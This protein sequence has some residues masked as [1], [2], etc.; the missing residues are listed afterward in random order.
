MDVTSIG[1]SD[2]GCVRRSNEDSIGLFDD[3]DLYI[4]ADGMGGHAAGEIASKMAVDQ[5][6]NYYTNGTVDGINDTSDRSSE[7][8]L[9]GAIRHANQQIYAE[10]MEDTSL[11]G[12]GTTVVTLLAKADEVTIGFV[13]DSRA[14]LYR[15]NQ[16]RQLTHDHS[17]VNEYVKR[18]ILASD[19]VKNHPQKHVLSR[20]LGTGAQVEVETLKRIPMAGDLFLLCSDGLSNKLTPSEIRSIIVES[21]GNIEETGQ[22]LVRMA[23]DNG[24]EDNISVVLVRYPA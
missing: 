3:L 4:V 23:K 21:K 13:G 2:I 7:A 15:N 10:S 9:T 19:A 18:G 11:N 16:V 5:I 8:A 20:A 22:R 1:I 12:M 6:K 17:L 24:G 14:Y